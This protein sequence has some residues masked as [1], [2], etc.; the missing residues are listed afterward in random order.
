[1]NFVYEFFLALGHWR[2]ERAR[3]PLASGVDG[4]EGGA[5]ECRVLAG[6]DLEPVGGE[7]V[8]DGG[9]VRLGLDLEGRL[10]DPGKVQG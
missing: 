1:M 5:D 10:L 3:K 7:Q 4:V 8:G 6:D 9:D 2:Q